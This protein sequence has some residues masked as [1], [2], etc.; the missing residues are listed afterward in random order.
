MKEEASMQ[1]RLLSVV[2]LSMTMLS[3]GG[4]EVRGACPSADINGDCFV[5]FEDVAVMACEW[6]RQDCS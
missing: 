3:V 6:L 4:M 2:F 5:N 1:S